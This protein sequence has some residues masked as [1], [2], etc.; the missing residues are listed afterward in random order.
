MPAPDPRVTLR[1]ATRSDVPAIAAMHLA[2]WR[3]TY[4]AI[5]PPEF[6]STITLEGRVKRWEAAFTPPA[7]ETTETTVAVDGQRILGVCS[8]GPRREPPDPGAGEIYSLH[9]GPGSLRAGIG[10]MLLDNALVRLGARGLTTVFLWVLRD[11]A[12]ARGFYEARGWSL[13]GEDRAD[14]RSGF[15]IAEVR[16]AIQQGTANG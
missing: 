9:V 13:T 11:N 15:P 12:N 2:S 3:A 8:F 10:R 5:T 14:D 4:T 1:L 7:S 16:Y 6:M